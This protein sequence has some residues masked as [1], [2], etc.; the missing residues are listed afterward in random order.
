M[1]SYPNALKL[2]MLGLSL[3]F[4]SGDGGSHDLHMDAEALCWHDGPT[5]PISLSLQDSTDD[6]GQLLCKGTLRHVTSH[7]ALIWNLGSQ[8]P[9]D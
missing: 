9:K 4:Y 2:H 8:L 3:R 6:A 7:G 5:M 1:L